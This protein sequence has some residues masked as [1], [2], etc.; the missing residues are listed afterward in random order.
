M[1]RI[2]RADGDYWKLTDE[3]YKK[4]EKE[5]RLVYTAGSATRKLIPES[6]PFTESSQ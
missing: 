4:A 5:K 1:I 6:K 3:E 2:S